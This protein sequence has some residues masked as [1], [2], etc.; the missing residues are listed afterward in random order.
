MNYLDFRKSKT[1]S[2]YVERDRPVEFEKNNRLQVLLDLRV[3]SHTSQ[4][5]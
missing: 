2:G 5:P 3:T 4:R 1:M